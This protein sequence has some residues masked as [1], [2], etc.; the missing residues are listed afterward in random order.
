M[1]STRSTIST[2]RPRLRRKSVT[3][4][5]GPLHQRPRL[6]R[7][8]PNRAPGIGG[9]AGHA[10]LGGPSSASGLLDGQDGG[11]TP[12][13]AAATD[14]RMGCVYLTSTPLS[15]SAP[16][17]LCFQICSRFAARAIVGVEGDPARAQQRSRRCSAPAVQRTKQPSAARP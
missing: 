15:T 10:Q 13:E 11:G 14:P 7:G 17:Y 2:Q 3:E 6:R 16:L 1:L 8:T 12:A 5:K 9:V 4:A